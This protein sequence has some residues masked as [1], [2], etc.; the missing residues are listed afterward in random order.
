MSL[1]YDLTA[2]GVSQVTGRMRIIV[3]ANG[4]GNIFRCVPSTE[5]LPILED[6]LELDL[7]TPF[8]HLARAWGWKCMEADDEASLNMALEAFVSESDH[9]CMLIIKSDGK[10]DADTWKGYFKYITESINNKNIKQ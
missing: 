2:L 6:C 3:L 5:S 1:A 9:P 7:N 8:M 4:G 10:T